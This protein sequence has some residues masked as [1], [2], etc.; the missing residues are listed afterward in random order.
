M[1]E[2]N[3]TCGTVCW[4]NANSCMSSLIN[5]TFQ[6]LTSIKISQMQVGDGGQWISKQTLN[7][8]HLIEVGKGGWEH[9]G[10][11]R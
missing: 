11:L 9:K 2:D 7:A 1:K 6:Q 10:L 3:C 5:K 8:T 4:I